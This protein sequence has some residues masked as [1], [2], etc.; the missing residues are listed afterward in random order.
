M[1][2]LKSVFLFKDL[3]LGRLIRVINI[4]SIDDYEGG[5]CRMEAV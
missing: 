5:C 1:E 4:A 2:V 3:S